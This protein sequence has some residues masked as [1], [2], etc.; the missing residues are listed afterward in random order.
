MQRYVSYTVEIV[1]C[2]SLEKVKYALS[3]DGFF[4]FSAAKAPFLARFKVKRCGI[5]SVE[6]EGLGNSSFVDEKISMGPEFWQAA[7]FKVGDD[8]R[9]DMLALQVISL[10]KNIFEQVNLDLF[11]FPYRVVATA[12]G[13]RN[14]TV[15]KLLKSDQTAWVIFKITLYACLILNLR[16]VL[17]SVCRMQNPAINS[18]V[19][20]MS[21]F[22]ST[23]FNSMETRIRV[24]FR[25]QG[26]TLSSQW[27]LT[28]L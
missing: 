23:S 20:Q 27:Q 5:H 26:E 16:M 13:V 24:H 1:K 21:V 19:P 4:F 11:L 17:S 18:A 10:F 6:S 7:I 28:Q 22:M 15:L 12:P 2:L 9:Q 3:T 14:A 25:M 8:V